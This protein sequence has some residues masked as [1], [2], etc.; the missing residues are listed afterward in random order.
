MGD[1]KAGKVAALTSA[2][3]APNLMLQQALPV[4]LRKAEMV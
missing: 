4:A 3:V 1:D 2:V